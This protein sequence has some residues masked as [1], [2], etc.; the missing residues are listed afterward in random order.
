[1][2]LTKI[3]K[4]QTVA[5]HCLQDCS[6]HRLSPQIHP[7]HAI[8]HVK[9]NQRVGSPSLHYFICSPIL[10][11]DTPDTSVPDIR[12]WVKMWS[13]LVYIILFARRLLTDMPPH[14]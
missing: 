7:L 13:H 5:T 8:S 12:L 14:T 1:M 3:D 10:N 9:V 4:K 2:K 11:K 6:A